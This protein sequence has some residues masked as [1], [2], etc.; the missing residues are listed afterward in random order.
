MKAE[1]FIGV[2][3]QQVK[4]SKLVALGYD[5]ETGDK[6]KSLTQAAIICGIGGNKD[7]ARKLASR[8]NQNP[9]IKKLIAYFREE[10]WEEDKIHHSEILNRYRD[11]VDK[12]VGNKAVKISVKDGDEKYIDVDVLVFKPSEAQRV[13][14]DMADI[15]GMK[16][17]KSV[18][19]KKAKDAGIY[20][21]IELNP[22]ERTARII[23]LLKKVRDKKIEAIH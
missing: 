13:L 7:S 5:P 4:F 16:G 10:T 23:H 8:Y 2:T 21:H 18:D 22:T 14:S 6:I 19:N 1:L 9:K 11:L 20:N 17:A 15:A 3:T 12:C